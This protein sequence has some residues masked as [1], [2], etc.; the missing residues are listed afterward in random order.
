VNK[1]R[2]EPSCGAAT[3]GLVVPLGH[4]PER[5]RRRAVQVQ[6]SRRPGV[7]RWVVAQLLRRLF[8]FR[9][10]VAI[11]GDAIG[12]SELHAVCLDRGADQLRRVPRAKPCRPLPV[13]GSPRGDEPRRSTQSVERRPRSTRSPP[14]PTHPM[15][16]PRPSW[17]RTSCL[18]GVDHLSATAS[19]PAW[20]VRHG[21]DDVQAAGQHQPADT[22]LGG[23]L[24]DVV[25]PDHV[26]R[27]KL[28]PR[29]GRI[30]HRGKAHHGVDARERC[31]AGLGVAHVERTD[32]V[33]SR[34]VR[35]VHVPVRRQQRSDRMSDA[36]GSPRDHDSTRC[37]RRHGQNATEV[38][39]PA[40]EALTTCRSR[41]RLCDN[42]ITREV[43]TALRSQAD[44]AVDLYA[45]RTAEWN[46]V[47]LRGYTTGTH[48]SR[49]RPY[50]ISPYQRMPAS[51]FG[52]CKHLPSPTDD[53]RYGLLSRA[54]QVRILPGAHCRGHPCGAILPG[55]RQGH[56]NSLSSRAARIPRV[57]VVGWVV[58]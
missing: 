24:G 28:F 9:S 17:R 20:P 16:Q 32:S 14:R 4:L 38:R 10:E 36:A 48:E 15:P 27:Q 1:D 45:I 56:P 33:A 51:K 8:E 39:T 13:P 50:P 37:L 43:A 6:L 35:T 47:D 53:A 52:T 49:K 58:Y 31:A 41:I 11:G 46:D 42:M 57:Q 30:R 29:G 55:T 22:T 54:S 40:A 21:R 7:I 2:R 44:L 23:R 34:E 19:C 5:E 18:D 26:D 12:H 3:V 25:G